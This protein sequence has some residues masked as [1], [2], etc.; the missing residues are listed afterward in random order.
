MIKIAI[1]MQPY[2]SSS[3]VVGPYEVFNSAGRNFNFI[4]GREVKRHFDI[5]LVSSDG[6]PVTFQG[7]IQIA[8]QKRLEE[9]TNPDIIFI[10]SCG[11]DLDI[12]AQ[13]L[14]VIEWI[15]ETA[16]QGGVIASVCTGL[17]L[18]A[19]TGLLDHKRATTHWSAVE[20]FRKRYPKIELVSDELFVEEGDLYTGGGSYAGNDLALHLVGRFCGETVK[21]ECAK[22]LVLD[23]R[24]PSQGSYTGILHHRIHSDAQIHQ[25][26]DML[27]KTYSNE[28]N[29]DEIARTFNM[30]PRNFHRRFKQACGETP[31]NY[32][33]KQRV[34]A[35]KGLLEQT[36]KNIVAIAQDVGYEDANYFREVF[37]RYAS[38]TPSAYREKFAD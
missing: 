4:T 32:L 13:K 18:F 1:Y 38:C 22:A 31:L 11:Y 33:Q 14:P 25:V 16:S 6:H 37:K 3:T 29:F 19:E 10:S 9:V 30:S 2:G 26:Q 34:E 21:R 20:E 15:K 24:R 8:A 12:S 35:A 27:E 7:G 17:G 36:K 23:T 5:E 28:I